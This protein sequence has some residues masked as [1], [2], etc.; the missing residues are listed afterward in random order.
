MKPDHQPLEHLLHA[1]KWSF[2]GFRAAWQFEVAFR[3]EV[4]ASLVILP[5]ALYLGE[6]SVEKVLLCGVWLLVMV[7]ELLNSAVEAV[8]DRVGLEHH[9][10]SGRAKDLGSAA[11]FLCNFIFVGTWSL[12]L[13]T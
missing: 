4:T 10:L 5:L 11:V 1:T 2:Q 9:E 6:S 7:V 13:L 3:I 12:L 8:V